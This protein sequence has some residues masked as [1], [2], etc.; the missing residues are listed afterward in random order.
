MRKALA[1]AAALIAAASI[2]FIAANDGATDGCGAIVTAPDGLPI[3]SA[4]L[5]E[6]GTRGDDDRNGMIL[7]DESGW[8]AKTMGNCV[9][10]L[11]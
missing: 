7:E 10:W 6:A 5:V 3:R 8:N 1:V 2:T 11:R 4:Q 9:G